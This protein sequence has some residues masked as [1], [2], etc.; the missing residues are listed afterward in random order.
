MSIKNEDLEG[1]LTSNSTESLSFYIKNPEIVTILSKS[2][3][4]VGRSEGYDTPLLLD[5]SDTLIAIWYHP[6]NVQFYIINK[7]NGS[8]IWTLGRPRRLFE[9]YPS[10]M[11]HYLDCK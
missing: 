4:E 5:T 3:F 1:N 8:G 6:E 2:S 7:E 11:I 9:D 10:G